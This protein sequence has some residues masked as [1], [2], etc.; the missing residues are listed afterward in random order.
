M[1][2]RQKLMNDGWFV[3]RG[4]LSEQDIAAALDRLRLISQHIDAYRHLPNIHPVTVPALAGHPDP[5]Y[6]YNWIDCVGFHDAVLWKTVSANPKLL[7]IA[8]Q[9]VGDD[10]FPLNGGGFFMKP[11]GSPQGV[12]WHQDASPFLDAWKE[13]DESNRLLFDFWLGLSEATEEMG[14]LRLIP[15]SQKLGRVEHQAKDG[16]LH[17][18]IDPADFGYSEADIVSIPTQPG[19]LIVWHQ[20]MF[21]GSGPNRGDKPRIAVASVYHG[22]A[23]EELLRAE[24]RR[25]ANRRRPQ[26]C[27][28]E[29]IFELE[30]AITPRWESQADPSAATEEGT[31]TR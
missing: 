23:D 22:R 20:D 9:V 30:D 3:V 27:D 1:S 11:P 28:G 16:A 19:D 12:P 5:L 7:A 8:R 2:Y 26:L 4:V 15:G 18:Q 29:K 10:V 6:H 14:C 17:P 13:D 21:H 25:G 24:H 31:V